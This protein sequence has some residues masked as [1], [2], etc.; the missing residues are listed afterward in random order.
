[1]TITERE[2]RAALKAAPSVTAAALS[3]GISR[4]YLHRLMTRYGIRVERVI[5]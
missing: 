4:Q 3:L 1:M 2:I 5:T